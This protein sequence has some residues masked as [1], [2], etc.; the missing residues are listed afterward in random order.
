MSQ[1]CFVGDCKSNYDTDKGT[2]ALPNILD[3]LRLQRRT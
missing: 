1:K 2:K 3:I